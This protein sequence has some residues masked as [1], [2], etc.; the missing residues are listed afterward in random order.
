M[1]MINHPLWVCPSLQLYYCISSFLLTFLF[2]YPV[3]SFKILSQVKCNTFLSKPILI[4]SISA[5]GVMIFFITQLETSDSSC[6]LPPL[7]SLSQPFS[8]EDQKALFP[9]GIFLYP[10]IPPGATDE[11]TPILLRQLLLSEPR[12]WHGYETSRAG[13]GSDNDHFLDNCSKEI[14]SQY[15]KKC[16]CCC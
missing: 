5:G 6:T 10:F 16:C 4:F 2:E 9:S 8:Q 13:V 7:P 1:K 15:L 12:V 3:I 14:Y 11:C